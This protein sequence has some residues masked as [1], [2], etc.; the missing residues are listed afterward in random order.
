MDISELEM[1]GGF[2]KFTLPYTWG[3]WVVWVIGLLIGMAGLVLPFVDANSGYELFFLSALGFILMAAVSPGSLE[4]GIYKVRQSAANPHDFEAIAEKKGMNVESWWLQQR[5][6]VPTNDPNDW[7][8]AAPGPATWNNADPYGP[9]EGGEPLPE[10]PVKVGTPIPATFSSYSLFSMMAMGLMFV[11]GASLMKNADNKILGPAIIS[12]VGLIALLFGYF[13]A[14]IVR[15]MLDTPTSLVR[16]MAVGN[17]EL[18][19]QVRP[20]P[21]GVLTVV[22]DSQPSMTVH[23]MVGYHWEYEQYQCRTVTSTDSE[24]NTT[25]EEECNWRTVRQDTGGCPFILHDGTG[26]VRVDLLSF[27]RKEWGQM[28]K[29]W[30]SKWAKSMGQQFMTNLLS[31]VSGYRVKDHRWTIYG[32]KMGNPVYVLGTS[33]IRSR[34]DLAR[35]GLDGTVQNSLLVMNGTD[36]PGVKA[37]LQRGTELAN[38]GRM[39][40]TLEMVILPAILM[41]GGIALFG[42]A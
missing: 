16:S 35:E 17:P 1:D 3:Q 26:G 10:H 14:K 9:H 22:V 25:S 30:D 23:N 12:V 34:E 11:A 4:A 36:A 8:L 5:S 33:A 13:K 32:L 24:G 15:Q 38:L 28:I 41:I 42:L 7:I 18:V 2:F 29:R 39:R 37:V 19:G 6:Y 20:A 27:K 31:G 21:E 40:S